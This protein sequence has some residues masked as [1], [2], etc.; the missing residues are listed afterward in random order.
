MPLVYIALLLRGRAKEPK[1]RGVRGH[2]H[3]VRLCA[4]LCLGQWKFGRKNGHV[5]EEESILLTFKLLV[6]WYAFPTSPALA[7]R[8]F[9]TEPPGKPISCVL[10]LPGAHLFSFLTNV[11][12]L[13]LLPMVPNTQLH[14]T[15][16]RATPYTL[17][18]YTIHTTQLHH[19]HY[20]ATPYTLHSYTQYTAKCSSNWTRPFSGLCCPLSELPAAWKKNVVGYIRMHS[21]QKRSVISHKTFVF[22]HVSWHTMYNIFLTMVTIKRFEKF[23][24]RPMISYLKPQNQRCLESQYISN[25]TKGSWCTTYQQGL[26]KQE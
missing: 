1:K 14:H 16:Y 3:C 6:S 17:Q 2:Q 9:T 18:S 11:H 4:V 7:G 8:F 23:D 15:H 20:T 26:G 21:N 22:R 10:S 13:V 19:T 25:S 24:Y 5:D 12:V